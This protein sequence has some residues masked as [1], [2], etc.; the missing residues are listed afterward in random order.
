MLALYLDDFFFF[1]IFK[2]ISFDVFYAYIGVMDAI[3]LVLDNEATN[4]I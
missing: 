4:F 1:S 3:D 2:I